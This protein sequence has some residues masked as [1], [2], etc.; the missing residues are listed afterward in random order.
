MSK[1]SNNRFI[2]SNKYTEKS[3]YPPYRKCAHHIHSHN[4]AANV[5]QHDEIIEKATDKIVS[6][7]T[8]S[9]I[10]IK[11]LFHF[12]IPK[13]TYNRN[14][15]QARAHDIILSLNDD[16]NNYSSNQNT[17]NNFKYKS[18]INQVFISNMAK[19]NIYLGK[20]YLNFL[21]TKPSN[22]I[23]E[24]GELYYYPVK[25]RLNLSQYDNLKDVEIMVQVIKQFIHQNRADAINPESL[26]NIWI[27]DMVDTKILSFSNFPWEVIDNYHGIVINRRVFFPED[28]EESNFSTFK[29]LTHAIGHYLGLLHVF[30]QNS[31]IGAYGAVNINADSEKILVDQ[32]P[33]EQEQFV[34]AFDPTD[35]ETNRRLHFDSTYNPLFMNFM[36]Y[37][38]DKYTV[39]FT[40]NQIKKMRYMANTYRPKMNFVVNKIKL[41]I[42]K[43]NPDTDTMSGIARQKY[44]VIKESP[45]IPS[46]EQIGNP[47]LL[48]QGS[49]MQKNPI[50]S[51]QE[52]PPATNKVNPSVVT[53]NA[54][55]L[56]LIPNL[57]ANINPN[58]T[59]ANTKE[60]IIHN[61]K[62]SLPNNNP[63][64]NKIDPVQTS[65]KYE[66]LV[67][68]YKTYY[69]AN[70]YATKYPYDPYIVQEHNNQMASWYSHMQKQWEDMAKRHAYDGENRIEHRRYPYYGY[71]YY[72]Y[73]YFNYRDPR[74]AYPMFD[75]RYPWNTRI[76]YPRNPNIYSSQPPPVKNSDPPSQTLEKQA[77]NIGNV[78]TNENN[79]EAV[80]NL[81]SAF[82]KVTKQINVQQMYNDQE[83]N[84]P[85]MYNDQE[86][87][88][89][90][91]YNDQ[92]INVPQMYNDQEINVPQ[93]YNDQEITEPE[94]PSHL[95]DKMSQTSNQMKNVKPKSLHNVTMND[96]FQQNN[97]E[98]KKNT[99]PTPLDSLPSIAN[100]K[101]SPRPIYQDN[102]RAPKRKFVRTKPVNI[103][104]N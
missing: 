17:M 73:P 36:D 8:D 38:Y 34:F 72:G 25:N 101:I 33:K 43:Y 44:H 2:V 103:S 94:S 32:E 78:Y 3:K 60:Q 55:I 48:A 46:Y 91:M 45:I 76:V 57:S 7:D 102:P 77:N 50:S 49:S 18:V 92:E 64:S 21:P 66:E 42:P 89:P 98:S 12:L 30:G 70:G 23:F 93:M 51:N 6:V 15:I 47:R 99:N 16:F 84:V 5:R 9:T 62:N 10:G 65:E 67:N 19:Q 86:I 79:Q 96:Y 87:N 11:I 90:Q 69:S 1:H 27:I 52:I 53:S 80:Q 35:K 88:V 63:D 71:P 82:P 14:K 104:D 83:I 20:E 85:Q 37:T 41:P 97:M 26:V 100:P 58:P 75:P 28:Y 29:T 39:M 59:T 4:Y 68:K 95:I 22:I 54:E 31:G 56:K 61:I 81:Q 24:L 40:N 13:G 74:F